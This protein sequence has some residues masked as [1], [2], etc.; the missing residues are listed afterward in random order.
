MKNILIIISYRLWKGS[1]KVATLP[2]PINVKQS[3]FLP[4]IAKTGV[5]SQSFELLAVVDDQ[6]KV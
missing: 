3:L 4:D 6:G 5:P 1:N 2:N